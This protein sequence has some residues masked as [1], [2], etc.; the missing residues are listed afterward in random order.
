MKEIRSLAP[1]RTCLFGDHQDYLGLPVIACA[2]DKSIKLVAVENDSEWFNISK[3]D[4]G[5]QRMIQIDTV[6]ENT[7]VIGDHF[8]AVLKVLQK[9][10]CIPNKGFDITITGT[11]PIN[12]GLSSSSAVVVAWT[13]FLLEAFGCT[14][15]VTQEF[16]A[17]IA[18]EAEVVEQKSSGGKMDQYSIS[19]GNIIYLETDESLAYQTI[20]KKL[21]GLIIGES[22]IPKDT[23]GTLKELKTNAI[24]SIEKV[25][26]FEGNFDIRKVKKND[27][28]TYENYLIP[29]LQPYFRAAILNYLI[30]KEALIEFQKE[31][32]DYKKIGDLMYQHHEIL[33]DL[34]HITVPRI[35]NMIDAAM[36]AGALGTKIVGSGKGGSIV[37]IAAEGKEQAVI[38]SIKH[39]GAVDAYL[40]SIDTGASIEYN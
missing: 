21:P 6:N 37:A 19:L 2:I 34:L 8:L 38:D 7:D 30:T 10:N 23:L 14:Q 20:P 16:I 1:G 40:V 28:E 24:L 13:Q 9:Y 39:A 36:N 26:E 5:E 29:E 31:V 18:Y 22:G 12:A 32:L 15:K 35:D 3:P 4:I 33:R 17:Q 25:K 11:I 27:I